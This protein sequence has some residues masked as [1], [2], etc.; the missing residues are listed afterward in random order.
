MSE[1]NGIDTAAVYLLLR[2][3]AEEPMHLPPA[4]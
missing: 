3:V 2:E 1:G 4:A